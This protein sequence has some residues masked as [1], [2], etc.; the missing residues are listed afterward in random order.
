MCQCFYR[1]R[2][3]LQYVCRG[4]RR[5]AGP[6][7]LLVQ[8]LHWC[9]RVRQPPITPQPTPTAL[10]ATVAAAAGGSGGVE[11]GDKPL[12]HLLQCQSRKEGCK[13]RKL[14]LSSPG[15][16][17]HSL[18]QQPRMNSCMT[19]HGR[20]EGRWRCIDG[21]GRTPVGNDTAVTDHGVGSV[22]CEEL[23]GDA[24]VHMH[25]GKCHNRKSIRQ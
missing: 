5:L 10:A 13:R 18:Q 4:G 25:I 3:A 8:L 12:H 14:L 22:R 1:C 17:L 9:D 16:I 15:L 11:V 19:D 20:K 7:T 2:Y 23:H 24:S 6:L 21:Q